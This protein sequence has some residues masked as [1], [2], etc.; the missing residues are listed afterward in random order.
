MSGYG[1]ALQQM[2]NLILQLFGHSCSIFTNTL[3]SDILVSPGF[4]SCFLISFFLTLLVHISASAAICQVHRRVSICEGCD[5][6]GVLILICS[7]AVSRTCMC[8]SHGISR[9][10]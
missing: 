10:K 9:T 1:L 7:D 3:T 5:L 6:P 8:V 4:V 2:T